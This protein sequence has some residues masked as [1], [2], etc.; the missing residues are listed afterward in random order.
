M[1][2]PQHTEIFA[3]GE[4]ADLD[5]LARHIIETGRKIILLQGELGAG[6]TA[7]VK[8]VCRALGSSDEVTSPTFTLVNEYRDQDDLP[9]FHI[10]LYRLET[11]EDA[12]QIGI[13]DYLN[14]GTWC[15]IEWPELILDLPDPDDVLKIFIETNPDE[16]RRMSILK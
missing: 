13:E 16:S 8:A 14:S 1:E 6:K 10:D 2:T 12:L 5:L 15:F 11:L 3:I 4:L 9:I 7:L